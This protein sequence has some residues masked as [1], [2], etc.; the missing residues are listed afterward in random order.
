M[1]P[2]CV[3]REGPSHQQC[4]TRASPGDRLKS[5][6]G[7]PSGPA[8]G[9]SWRVAGRSL[10]ERTLLPVNFQTFARAH[11]ES[12]AGLTAKTSPSCYLRASQPVPVRSWRCTDNGPLRDGHPLAAAPRPAHP[13]PF[14][15]AGTALFFA[16]AQLTAALSARS[17][18][19]A[20]GSC[21]CAS[22]RRPRQPDTRPPLLQKRSAPPAVLAIVW[23]ALFGPRW[24]GTPVAGSW[25]PGSSSP[26]R[27]AASPARSRAGA[28]VRGTDVDEP[29]VVSAEDAR[30]KFDF[31]HIPSTG[32]I[33]P[34]FSG[35]LLLLISNLPHPAAGS[36]AVRVDAVRMATS[37]YPLSTRRSPAPP[38]G[39]APRPAAG[40][41]AACPAPQQLAVPSMQGASHTRSAAGR[42]RPPTRRH[43]TNAREPRPAAGAP[44]AAT[45]AETRRSPR[46]LIISAPACAVAT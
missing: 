27:A 35:F 32:R 19:F 13:S 14:G 45:R 43:R 20:H 28:P 33:T 46:A 6:E 39:A 16:P 42:A 23:T 22:R 2:S 9:S 17:C 30:L 24:R 1:V 37:Q 38:G 36:P 3:A 8:P 29:P 11:P 7:A 5:C 25:G 34:L 44:C 4:R 12:L 40:S 31:E 10:W 41:G 26:G 21:S 18:Y 15:T